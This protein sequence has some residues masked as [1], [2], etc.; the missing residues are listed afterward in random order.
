MD[1]QQRNNLKN[2][3]KYQRPSYKEGF[4]L[5]KNMN[6]L[7]FIFIIVSGC[8]SISQEECQEGNW[9]SLGLRDGS[10][11]KRALKDNVYQKSCSE[12]NVKVDREKYAK[13]FRIGLKKYC[14]YENGKVLGEEGSQ[15]HK[16]CTK[17]S[18]SFTKGYADGL[19]LYAKV[20]QREELLES[21]KSKYNTK[22]CTFDSDCNQEGTCI[23]SHICLFEGT[24]NHLHYSCTL[25]ESCKIKKSCK[26]IT[27]WTDQEEQV[28]I[29]LCEP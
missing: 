13:G 7:L 15:K 14:T 18:H 29:N 12:Y 6:L 5:E 20:K 28:T 1:Q 23:G 2:I 21:I 24:H 25:G 27:E 4:F 17:V 16:L 3:L 9:Y 10:S 11:G 19:L 22:E 8:S 26:R